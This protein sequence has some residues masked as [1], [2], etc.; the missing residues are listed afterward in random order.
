MQTEEIVILVGVVGTGALIM[1]LLMW[2]ASTYNQRI[3][4]GFKELVKTNGTIVDIWIE[5]NDP[6]YTEEGYSPTYEPYVI[7]YSYHDGRNM[8]EKSFKTGNRKQV[9]KLKVNDI[10][11]VYYD[12][13]EPDNAVAAIQLEQEKSM[14]WKILLGFAVVILSAVIIVL[15]TM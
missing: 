12:R 7:T 13:Q 15:C 5:R 4:Q 2:F 11:V 1:V 6:S 9:H 8:H 3:L 10:L 14:W